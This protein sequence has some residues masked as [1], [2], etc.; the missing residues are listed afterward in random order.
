MIKQMLTKISIKLINIPIFC[1]RKKNLG[2]EMKNKKKV[3]NMN[4][5]K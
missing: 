5:I 2:K 4:Y 3:I 1:K